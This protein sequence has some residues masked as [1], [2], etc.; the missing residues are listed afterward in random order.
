MLHRLYRPA[1]ILLF[2]WVSCLSG[3]WFGRTAWRFLHF[4]AILFLFTLIGGAHVF[5]VAIGAAL[6]HSYALK[7]KVASFAYIHHSVAPF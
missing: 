4:A 3:P 2:G 1:A 6:D 5:R 7:N